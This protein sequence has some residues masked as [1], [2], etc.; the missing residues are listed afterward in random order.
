MAGVVESILL[1][2]QVKGTDALKGVAKHLTEIG[3][4]AATSA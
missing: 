2:V 3:E 4:A 1:D